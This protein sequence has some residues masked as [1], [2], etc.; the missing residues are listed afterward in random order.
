MNPILISKITHNISKPANLRNT[1][2]YVC[3]S[4]LLI[5]GA[6]PSCGTARGFGQDVR[7]TGNEIQ[8]AANRVDD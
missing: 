7:A 2:L 8:N 1:A 4:L 6:A 3:A 5:T